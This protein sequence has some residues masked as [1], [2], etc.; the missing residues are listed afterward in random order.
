MRRVK[1]RKE[2]DSTEREGPRTRKREEE[3][4]KKRRRREEKREERERRTIERC[5]VFHH[6]CVESQPVR[7]QILQELGADV[8]LHRRGDGTKTIDEN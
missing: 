8:L 7:L 4:K 6:Q 5:A 3:R 1:G 2:A